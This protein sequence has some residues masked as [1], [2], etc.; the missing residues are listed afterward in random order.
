MQLIFANNAQT[1]LA[2]SISNTATSANLASGS[3][4]LFPNPTPTAQYFV[5]TFT[6]AATGLLREIVWVTARTGDSITILRGQEG[7][8]A[9]NWSANDLFAELW[10]AGQ[11][12]AFVQGSGS[13]LAG[14]QCYLA[15]NGANLQLSPD[16]GQNI[17]I[18]GVQYPIP[19]TGPTL[20][21][22]ALTPG[23][24]YYIYAS[25]STGAIVL[26]A[27][28]TGHETSSTTGNVGTEIMIG[29]NTKS[30]VG[31]WLVATGPV[32]STVPTQGLSWFNKKTKFN[33]TTFSTIRTTT[34][35]SLVE[36]NSEIRNSFIIFAGQTVKWFVN[37]EIANSAGPGSVLAAAFNGTSPEPVYA[38]TI[39]VSG[40]AGTA[41]GLAE[42]K[43]GLSEGVN[44]AT[45]LGATGTSGSLTVWGP[46]PS[47]GGSV[48][49]PLYLTVEVDG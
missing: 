12:A 3:G 17:V 27:S 35:N 31:F 15:L 33:R 30:F 34:S 24:A 10:T 29:D 23:S 7:T 20:A 21:P 44:Y 5:G 16:N 13:N 11:A 6:D 14:G 37:G 18:D 4:A 49:V 41:P 38:V 42:F 36:I 1:T 28:L 25:I 8:T 46:P 45:V 32:W 47:I 43:T 19:A 40:D 26:S 39:P 22:T 9:L 2:G 48:D